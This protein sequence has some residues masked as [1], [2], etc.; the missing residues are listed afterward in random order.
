MK[1]SLKHYSLRN[2]HAAR[3]AAESLPVS[4]FRFDS[5]QSAGGAT[6]QDSFRNFFGAV[7]FPESSRTWS[8]PQK[9]VPR[10]YAHRGGR[11]LGLDG[12]YLGRRV[13]CILCFL[14]AAAPSPSTT[15]VLNVVPTWSPSPLLRAHK[16]TITVTGEVKTDYKW[17]STT[18]YLLMLYSK[19]WGYRIFSAG[20]PLQC[21]HWKLGG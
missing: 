12:T 17:G 3:A 7:E 8:A 11:P 6:A 21:Y 18:L 4:I 14:P 9:S 10:K 5:A 16:F 13:L 2:L 20:A 19:S 15:Y 1:K